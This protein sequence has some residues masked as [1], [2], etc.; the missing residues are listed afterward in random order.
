MTIDD[1]IERYEEKKTDQLLLIQ[2]QGGLVEEAN[3]A[4]KHVLGSRNIKKADIQYAEA[5]AKQEAEYIE[6]RKK[7][8]KNSYKAKAIFAGLMILV[9]A[10]SSIYDYFS[11]M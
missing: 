2:A 9:V 6:S 7:D 4:L 1:F 11:N 3:V 10:V 5:V 8:V